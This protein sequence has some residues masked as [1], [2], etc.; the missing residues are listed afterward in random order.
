MVGCQRRWKWTMPLQGS[1]SEGHLFPVLGMMMIIPSLLR[2]STDLT[3][4]KRESP[5]GHTSFSPLCKT[6]RPS[7]GILKKNWRPTPAR[8]MI[9][10]R[11]HADNNV[12]DSCR[13]DTLLKCN[14]RNYISP[15]LGRQAHD[16]WLEPT[17]PYTRHFE[18]SRFLCANGIV[19][20]KEIEV[21]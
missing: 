7:H 9:F 19:R 1:A 17:I 12:N 18:Y 21:W 14:W 15:Q 2:T 3:S 4:Q 6:R 10:E 5:V 8:R 20:G 11:K 16:L 13:L